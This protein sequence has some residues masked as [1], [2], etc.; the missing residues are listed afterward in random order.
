ML[1][2]LLASV[3]ITFNPISQNY[4][5]SE[6]DKSNLIRSEIMLQVVLKNYGYYSS[7]IDGDFGPLSALALKDFQTGIDVG[8]KN[9]V[10]NRHL[11]LSKKLRFR[12]G[13]L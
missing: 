5:C 6:Y 11:N 8:C 7:K 13:K 12:L 4:S 10:K 3:I 2:S 9:A 1:I